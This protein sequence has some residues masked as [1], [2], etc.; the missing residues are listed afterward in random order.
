MNSRSSGNF[1]GWLCRAT[2]APHMV[3]VSSTRWNACPAF[4]QSALT[5]AVVLSTTAA[6]AKPRS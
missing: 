5:S 4:T 3:A 2:A 1:S 6:P